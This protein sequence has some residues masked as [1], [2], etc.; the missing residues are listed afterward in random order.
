[1]K[2]LFAMIFSLVMAGQGLANAATTPNTEDWE[3]VW[4]GEVVPSGDP[5]YSSALKGNAHSQFIMGMTFRYERGVYPLSYKVAAYWLKKAADQ[6]HAGAQRD[7]AILYSSGRGVVRNKAIAVELLEAAA[8]TGLVSAQFELAEL[9]WKSDFM[10]NFDHE[11]P[12]QLASNH[13]RAVY[14][15][16][17]VSGAPKDEELYAAR[18]MAALAIGYQFGNRVEKDMSEAS[19]W[20]SRA[21]AAGL[22]RTCARA[23]ELKEQGY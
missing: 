9:L 4:T 8:Q 13:K 6:G 14:W 11:T 23:L 5:L 17:K 22:S 15:Y 12:E 7:L 20:F 10:F 2:R 1:M 16:K 18:A 19:L 21:C 3:L